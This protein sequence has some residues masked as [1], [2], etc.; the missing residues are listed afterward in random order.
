MACALGGARAK[1]QRLRSND[2]HDEH[3]WDRS[4]DAKGR[5]TFPTKEE[6]DYTA[7]LAFAIATALSRWAVK[8]GFAKLRIPRWPVEPVETGDRTH[9]LRLPPAHLRARSDATSSLSVREPP[10]SSPRIHATRSSSSSGRR[11]ERS[12]FRSYAAICSRSVVSSCAHSAASA[13]RSLS[14]RVASAS[15]ASTARR[16]SEASRSSAATA[17][18]LSRLARFADARASASSASRRRSAFSACSARMRSDSRDDFPSLSAPEA[19]SNA[20]AADSSCRAPAASSR[21]S[22]ARS[23]GA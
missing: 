21:P 15:A 6:A 17:S 2:V 13:S 23:S 19:K 9:T 20:S 14:R 4:R 5:W 3:E 22:S 8:K 10:R 12:V 7:A 11:G 1:K 16:A 18:A